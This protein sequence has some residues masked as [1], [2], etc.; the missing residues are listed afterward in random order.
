MQYCDGMLV[1]DGDDRAPLREPRA[2]LAVLDQ[3]LAQTVEAVGDELVGR[4]RERRRALVDLD[5]G[6]DALRLEDLRERAAVG[7]VLADRLVE[8]DHAADVVGRA[9]RS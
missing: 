2:E 4:L 6:D 1:A 5:A 7:G 8:Q 3:P 9:R